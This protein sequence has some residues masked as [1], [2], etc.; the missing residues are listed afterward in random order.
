MNE[1]VS[2]F[3]IFLKYEIYNKIYNLG[4]KFLKF[5]S[6]QNNIRRI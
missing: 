2:N 1:I 3:F 6:N 5:T 4:I